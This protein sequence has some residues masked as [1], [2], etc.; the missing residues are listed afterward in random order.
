VV[1]V[2]FLVVARVEAVVLTGV[3]VGGA[4]KPGGPTVAGLGFGGLAFG[5]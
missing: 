5:G 2:V 1:V 3:R 4:N